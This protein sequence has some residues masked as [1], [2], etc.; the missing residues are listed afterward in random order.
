[1]RDRRIWASI[2]LMAMLAC[3][4]ALPGVNGQSLDSRLRG[5][6]NRQESVRDNLKD[7][8]AQQTARRKALSEARGEPTRPR[9][10]TAPRRAP[11]RP[12]ASI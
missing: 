4:T 8:K 10:R 11:L 7:V 12:R 5:T 9:L 3:L 2:G 6:K 1:M